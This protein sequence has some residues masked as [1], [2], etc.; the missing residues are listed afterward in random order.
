MNNEILSKNNL[1]MSNCKI[2]KFKDCILN[3]NTGLNPRNNFSLGSGSIKYITA[4]NL[5]KSGSIDFS[6][7]DFID[8]KAKEI[9]HKRS[10]IQMGDILFSSRAPVGHCHLIQDIPNYYDIG[11][12][13]FSIRVNKEVILPEY[14]CLYLTSDYFI[15]SASKHTTGSV[16]QEI[17]IAN[18]MNINII[19]PTEDIQRKISKIIMSINKKVENN[20]QINNYLE[21]LLSIFYRRWFLEYEFQNNDG[22]SYKSNGG[23]FVYN[24]EIKQEIPEGWKVENCYKNTLYEILKP[25]VE[26]FESK[27]YLATGNINNEDITDG[28]WITFENR[29][30]RAN[31]QPVTNSIWFAK[32]KNSIKHVTLVENSEW[33]INKYI[34]STGFLGIQCKNNSLGYIHSFIYSEYFEKVKDMLSH[35]ATQ[36]AINNDDL[37]HIN[38]II[39]TQ[40]VLEKY[41]ELT[42]DI[43]RIK[44]NIINENQRLTKLKEYL[45]PL[46]MNGQI[47]VDDI[48]I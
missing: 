27:N 33:F 36:E 41:E 4:K 10:D 17:R 6:K 42:K 28:D 46:L 48:E 16:I 29:E 13:I 45:L 35:G 19:I 47:N 21:E 15:N 22:K 12:S 44:D 3:L 5:N 7:C 40:D 18:L 8:E 37:K 20:N 1:F 23:K 26:H 34:L 43:L 24:E 32:M 25:G 39:P 30:S 11:E 9:I 14:M 38:L 31:M 2:L